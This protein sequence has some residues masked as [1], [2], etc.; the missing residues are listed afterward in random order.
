M[1][2]HCNL[3]SVAAEE[4][5]LE[6]MRVSL[7]GVLMLEE[8]CDLPVAKVWYQLGLWLGV[9]ESKLRDTKRKFS[10]ST[11]VKS[12]FELFLRAPSSSEEYKQ[13]FN[14]LQPGKKEIV[15]KYFAQLYPE[16]LRN[17]QE[18]MAILNYHEKKTLDKIFRQQREKLVE[19]L[20]KVGSREVAEKIC[21]SKGMCSFLLD[22][23]NDK[24]VYYILYR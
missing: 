12:M 13:L 15:T 6:K 16:Q 3:G 10:T 14:S 24:Q 18:M 19:A 2:K 23:Y 9:N 7:Q 21:Q 17:Y 22:Y 11:I 5:P 20:V 1:I 4:T 8:L